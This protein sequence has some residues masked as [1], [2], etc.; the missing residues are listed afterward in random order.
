MSKELELLKTAPK[1]S[2]VAPKKPNSTQDWLSWLRIGLLILAA[3]ILLG[4][5]LAGGARDVLTKA[6][7]ICTECIGLG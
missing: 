7:N 6:A 2:R 1:Q 5:A 4:G 3:V